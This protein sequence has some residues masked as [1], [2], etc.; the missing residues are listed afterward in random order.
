MLHARHSKDIAGSIKCT[1]RSPG[2]ARIMTS[3]AVTSL[4]LNDSTESMKI[5]AIDTLAE[6]LA[7]RESHAPLSPQPYLLCRLGTAST[8]T[9]AIAA[10]LQAFPGPV[11]G[12]GGVSGDDPL[13]AACD[14]VVAD[15]VQ[16]APLV[17]N[18]E[19]SPIA[20][21]VLV[22]TLRACGPLPLADALN[23]ESLAYAT[24]QS[25]RV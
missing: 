20:A 16:A 3:R 24:L 1:G 4:P 5:H 19:R 25:G 21:S 2:A 12:V 9:A 13:A 11:I 23:L 18:I 14:T 7:L 22:Q 6:F 15:A 8:E 17:T 10:A